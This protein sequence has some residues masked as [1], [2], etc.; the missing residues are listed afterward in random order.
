[1]RSVRAFRATEWVELDTEYKMMDWKDPPRN[2]L[3]HL[4]VKTTLKKYA[5]LGS[6]DENSAKHR[7][8]RKYYGDESKRQPWMEDLVTEFKQLAPPR[9]SARIADR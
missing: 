5:E 8:I 2:P 1:M 7:C 9:V 6:N 3:Q 4:N